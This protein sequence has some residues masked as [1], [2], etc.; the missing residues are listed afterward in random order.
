MPSLPPR[1]LTIAGSDCSGGAGLQADLKT[2]AA[3][4]VY[5]MSVITAVTAQNTV[6]VFGVHPVPPQFV[7][8][9]M[10]AVF[11]DIGV[12]A[13]KIGMLFDRSL[14]EAVA[15]A[16]ESHAGPPI[17]LDT[18]MISKSGAELLQDDAVE[19]LKQ[20]LV[21]LATIIT[22]NLPEAARLTG[23]PV[24]TEEEREAVVARL[25]EECDSV[26]LKG[27]HAAGSEICDFL[28]TENRVIRFVHPRIETS[29]TH[30]TGCTL[31]AAIAARLGMGAPI[32]Q[33]VEAA[34]GYTA[35]AIEAAVPLGQGCGPLDH[36][37]Q[38]QGPAGGEV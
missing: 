15:N 5:G 31:S 23:M 17:V 34:I 21:P 9:Q 25:V 37:Y 3:H 27:G 20:L 36:L 16:L 29:S 10:D 1:I 24:E 8:Q 33:A 11:D 28:G 38:M 6:D 12:D 14:I 2:F 18:V 22:P 30:G 35:A 19:S 13:I 4:R 7:R 32:E 26:L